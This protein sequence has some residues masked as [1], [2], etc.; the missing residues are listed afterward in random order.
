MQTD[1]QQTSQGGSGG[2]RNEGT[3]GRAEYTLESGCEN[4]I[5]PTPTLPPA[6]RRVRPFTGVAFRISAAASYSDSFGGSLARPSPHSLSQEL[7]AEY[8]QER[9]FHT[10]ANQQHFY[11]EGVICEYLTSHLNYEC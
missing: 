8:L 7:R 5:T 2:R 11:K 1:S 3:E 4:R 9:S 6:R 10:G